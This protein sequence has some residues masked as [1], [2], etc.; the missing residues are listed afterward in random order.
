MAMKL[1]DSTLERIARSKANQT[2]K[3]IS[4]DQQRGLYLRVGKTGKASW[5][6]VDQ[7]SGKFSTRTFGEWPRMSLAKARA[8][9]ARMRLEDR[10]I[11]LTWD[12]AVERFL[13]MKEGGAKAYREVRTAPKTKTQ[14]AAA[15]TKETAAQRSAKRVLLIHF[16]E[17]GPVK[18]EAL[19]RERVEG[20]ILAFFKD[21]PETAIKLLS[22][23]KA[24][25]RWCAR[26]GFVE[27]DPLHLLDKTIFGSYRSKPKTRVATDNEIRQIFADETP[28]GVALRWQLLTACRIS[29]ALQFDSTQVDEH[30]V[31]TIPAGATKSQREHRVPLSTMARKIAR[32]EMPVGISYSGVAQHMTKFYGELNT[33]DARRTA[34]TRARQLGASLELAHYLMNH[35]RPILDRTYLQHDMVPEAREALEALAAHYQNVLRQGAK[36]TKRA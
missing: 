21:K 3:L 9:A 10:G 2:G 7:R 20:I 28:T 30:G 31:W 33:H 34:A 14:K 4:D 6:L 15:E 1:T 29:E 35:A 36:A 17:L 13:G 18:L 5:C 12:S 23:A 32:Q 22:Q 8:E 27:H 16:A 24:L 25:A 11:G 19:K 26:K